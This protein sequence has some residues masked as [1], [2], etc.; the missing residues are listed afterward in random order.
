M[1]T[2]RDR[3]GDELEAVVVTDKVVEFDKVDED[4]TPEEV[5]PEVPSKF[6][7]ESDGEVGVDMPGVLDILNSPIN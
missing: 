6:I 3:I 4:P 2:G 1:E 7:L 5:V